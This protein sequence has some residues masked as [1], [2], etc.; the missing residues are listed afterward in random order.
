MTDNSSFGR[1]G[2]PGAGVPQDTEASMTDNSSFG[3][4]G[5]PGAGVPQ[6]TEASMTDNS[7]L[8]VGADRVRVSRKIRRPQP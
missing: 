5:R 4:G 3:R 7:R 1:G 2:R 8:V 6:D